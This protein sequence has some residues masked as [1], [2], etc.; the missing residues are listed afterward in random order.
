MEIASRMQG[1]VGPG[2]VEAVSWQDWLLQFGAASLKLREAVAKVTRWLT[3]TRP[4]WAAY[5]ALVAGRLIVL[6]KCPG[7]RPVGVGEILL[8][9]MGKCVIAV[10]GEDAT[11]VCGIKEL[12]SGLK[13]G[14]EGAIHTM[15]HLWDEHGEEENWGVLL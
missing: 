8:H 3:N 10:C 1:S 6:D 15:N 12:C 4:A 11:E 7:V 2:G 14:I 13:A 9:M 5:C